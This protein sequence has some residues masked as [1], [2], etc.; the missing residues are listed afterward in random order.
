M[1]DAANG[2]GTVPPAPAPAEQP[3][4]KGWQSIGDLVAK[5]AGRI[6]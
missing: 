4:D 2:H 6:K 3:A 5:I 1:T